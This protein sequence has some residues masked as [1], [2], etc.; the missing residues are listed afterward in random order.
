V[1]NR[2][3]SVVVAT[4]KL[5]E[6]KLGGDRDAARGEVDQLRA[7][8]DLAAQAPDLDDP[9]RALVGGRQQTHGRR[10]GRVG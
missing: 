2:N 10:I 8:D 9:H 6:G 3:P 5:S 7:A 4:G 1:F